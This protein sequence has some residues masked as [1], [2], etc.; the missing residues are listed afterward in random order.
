MAW[1]NLK[2]GSL[3]EAMLIDQLRYSAL[4]IRQVLFSSVKVSF[5]DSVTF[6]LPVGSIK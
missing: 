3:A 1:K 6:F 4:R 2:Q 5:L